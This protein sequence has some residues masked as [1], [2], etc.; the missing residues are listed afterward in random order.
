M[1]CTINLHVRKKATGHPPNPSNFEVKEK[2]MRSHVSMPSRNQQL[3]KFE[4]HT[5]RNRKTSKLGDSETMRNC[6]VAR[7][8]DV[9]ETWLRI[10]FSLT[11][12]FDGLGGWPVA[13]LPDVQIYCTCHEFFLTKSLTLG[14]Q[15]LISCLFTA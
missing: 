13:L 12:K 5:L 10:R 15:T 6:K 2:R 3:M 7:F 9:A 1:T 14:V 8:L 4:E 11:S